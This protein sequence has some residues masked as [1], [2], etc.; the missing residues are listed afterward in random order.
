M[1]WDKLSVGVLLV[2]L[3]WLGIAFLLACGLPISALAHLGAPVP[4]GLSRLFVIGVFLWIFLYFSMQLDGFQRGWDLS[5]VASW[6]VVAVVF[7]AASLQFAAWIFH[8]PVSRAVLG[9]FAIMVYSGCLVIRLLARLS[10]VFGG[11]PRRFV[12]L[13]DGREARELA[14]E[15]ARHP[16]LRAQ[17]IGFFAAAGQNGRERSTAELHS[18]STLNIVDVLK[19]KQVTDLVVVL[20]RPASREVTNLVERCRA[21]GITI[22]VV[23]EYYHLYLTRP[24]LSEVGGIPLLSIDKTPVLPWLRHLKPVLDFCLALFLLVLFAPVMVL[25]AGELLVHKGRILATETR[26]GLHG[27]TF[28]MYRFAIS[29][30]AQDSSWLM[31]LW[32]ATSLTEI[33]QL[34]NVLRGDMSVIGPRPETPERAKHYSEWHR[35]RLSVKPGI[36]G[37]AQVH[38]VR[39][40]NPSD[41]KTRFDLHYILTWSPLVDVVIALQTG[42]TLIGR[43]RHSRSL[44]LVSKA[45]C[46][47]EH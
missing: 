30:D 3:P 45:T 6:L 10:I 11:S 38:G 34:W 47:I 22:S 39:D 8:V 19:H 31:R 18:I 41:E 2:D 16:E 20:P 32:R 25:M 14:A 23:P 33:P 21:E 27:K 28:T 9:Y 35:Q 46:S 24:R 5:S 7:L 40:E 37:W 15:L 43:L 12:I 36:T 26:C 13:G 29:A 42:W 44:A 17:V 1:N 4:V